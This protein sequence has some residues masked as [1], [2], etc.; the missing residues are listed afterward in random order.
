[1][2]TKKTSALAVTIGGNV[3]HATTI[4]LSVLLFRNPITTVNALGTVT[5]ILGAGWYS[6]IDYKSKQQKAES[7]LSK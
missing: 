5:T 2:T 1:M 3:K 6:W 4:V 7:E